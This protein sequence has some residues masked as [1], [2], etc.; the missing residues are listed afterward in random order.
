MN[1]IG[2]FF[3]LDQHGPPLIVVRLFM[4]EPIVR[5]DFGD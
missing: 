1:A 3:K 5:V 2:R 4:L